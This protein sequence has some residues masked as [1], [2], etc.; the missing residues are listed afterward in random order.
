MRDRLEGYVEHIIFRNTENGY[1]VFELSAKGDSICCVGALPSID[2]GEYLKLDGTY[3][4][5]NV[6]GEQFK[7][8]SFSAR[9]PE[10]QKALERYLASGAI[11][12][13]GAALAERIISSFG[14][15]TLRIMEEEPE[16]LAEVKG[17]SKKK[18]MEIAV[19]ME[20]KSQLRNDMIFLSQFDISFNLCLK[21]HQKY[22]GE[23]YDI[24]QYNPY[25]IAE[26]ISGVGFKT[27]DMIASRV[28]IRKNSPY[29]LKSGYL[30]V[31]NLAL[32]EGHTY[33][34]KDLLDRKTAAMLE[35]E[36]EE[37]KD[38][39]LELAIE[40]RLV[41]KQAIA[42]D[43]T[44][45]VFVYLYRTYYLELT[46]AAKLVRMNVISEQDEL[47][48]DKIL[49]TI[50][51]NSEIRL[52]ELQ[53]EAVKTAAK[54]GITILTG[55]P[56]TGKTT[57]INAMIRFFEALGKEILLAAPTG[58]AA[59]RMQEATGYAA[60]TI[61]RL[62]EPYG[63]PEEASEKVRFGRNADNPLEADVIIIDEASMVDIFLMS[64]L[65]DAVTEGT[66]F[67]FV[68]D[69]NQLPS[70]GPGAVLQDMI[71]SGR[72]SVIKLDKIFRQAALSDI[73]VNAHKINRGEHLEMKNND[74]D[75]IFFE[76]DNALVLQK[77]VVSLVKDK[78]PSYLKI[79][80][81]DIQVLTPMRKGA[82]GVENLNA[83]LQKYLNPPSPDKPEHEYGSVIFRT[84][85]KVMQIKNN[86]QLEWE[87]RGRYGIPIDSG[88]GVFNGDVGT[89]VEI[90]DFD[91]TLSVEYDD[92]RIVEYAY[93]Q[94][95]ELELAY[96]M[97]VHKAQGSE[98]AAIVMPIL[99]GPGPLLTRNLLYTAVTRAKNCAALA[100][101]SETINAMID[102][103]M[104]TVRY[105]SLKE[106]IVEM[107]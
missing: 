64:S 35:V 8:S 74:G 12:G 69:I 15:D 3:T 46:I 96:A 102:N 91:E 9:I 98:Y 19:Q 65:L 33:L 41:S 27:A 40:K 10:E 80:S 28:G 38:C 18:A 44:P 60:S 84:G 34:P 93:K 39:F 78:L 16:R 13:I 76:R 66:R 75:F 86:Y 32:N 17:I 7:I 24:L 106:R 71:N 88:T 53:K 57:T 72:F 67:V 54:H 25:K 92:M 45:C 1:T 49:E 85:D 52:E 59:K 99:T 22:H 20:E 23:I 50:E 77:V 105:T 14:D 51:K 63:D 89:I 37:L 2:V 61:H 58:R 36:E 5:H 70:V 30:Y 11:K 82:L 97:T 26:D 103:E 101:S 94:L 83:L 95:D 31:L 55:G 4:F 43:G 6:Y 73:V 47:L 56:G 62:L 104:Q 90:S 107:P 29:R 48:V 21:I 68:G 42:E 79:K 100:G 87:I 81:R